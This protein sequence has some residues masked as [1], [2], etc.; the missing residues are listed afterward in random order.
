MW[1]RATVPQAHSVQMLDAWG[2]WWDN[3]WRS[4][5]PP[6]RNTLW[7]KDRHRRLGW[8]CQKK[9]GIPEN[10]SHGDPL[11]DPRCKT[12]QSEIQTS[13]KTWS[14]PPP[15]PMVVAPPQSRQDPGHTWANT[16]WTPLRLLLCLI[17]NQQRIIAQEKAVE[18][19]CY[20]MTGA[21]CALNIV[22]KR[23]NVRK[24]SRGHE[25]Y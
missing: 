6:T 13:S 4:T 22:R 11:E 15:D 3:R 10:A 12:E 21:K 18:T 20:P 14:K 23:S 7:H 24:G 19:H 8:I 17:N 2:T 5:I 25:T 9:Q 16:N 1:S